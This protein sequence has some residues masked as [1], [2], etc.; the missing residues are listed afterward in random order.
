MNQKFKRFDGPEYYNIHYHFYQKFIDAQK[1]I[2]E[3]SM[4]ALNVWKL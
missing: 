3:T 4:R 2:L 1:L